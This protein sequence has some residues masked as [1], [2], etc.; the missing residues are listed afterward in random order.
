MGCCCVT[1]WDKGPNDKL[2]GICPR[3]LIYQAQPYLHILGKSPNNKLGHTI[4]IL[5]DPRVLQH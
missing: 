4:V 3:F 2:G 5:K 1:K